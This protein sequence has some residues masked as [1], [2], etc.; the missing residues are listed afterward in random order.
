MKE[1]DHDVSIVEQNQME[2]KLE[3]RSKYWIKAA[4]KELIE[5]IQYQIKRVSH[6]SDDVNFLVDD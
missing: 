5:H 2:Q 4:G 1:H 3:N 6:V